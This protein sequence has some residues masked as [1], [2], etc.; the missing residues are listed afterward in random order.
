MCG[1][2]QLVTRTERQLCAFGR[3]VHCGIPTGF[4]R[5]IALRVD[6]RRHLVGSPAVRSVGFSAE[7]DKE[8]SRND[9]R[10]VGVERIVNRHTERDLTCTCE[11]ENRATPWIAR[12]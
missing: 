2:A 8:I 7:R 1:F 3:Y 4:P 5:S 10:S 9:Q 11:A 12:S 6:G